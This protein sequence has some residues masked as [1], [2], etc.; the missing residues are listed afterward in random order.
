MDMKTWQKPVLSKCI[1]V[2][3]MYLSWV[4]W[5]QVMGIEIS[6]KT[7]QRIEKLHAYKTERITNTT[8]L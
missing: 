3:I 5:E 4:V 6:K 7:G 8:C 1:S 2:F